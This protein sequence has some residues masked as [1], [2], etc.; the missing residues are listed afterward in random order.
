MAEVFEIQAYAAVTAIIITIIA[1]HKYTRP[2]E[3]SWLVHIAQAHLN[4]SV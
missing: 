4:F 1:I 2:I 3:I